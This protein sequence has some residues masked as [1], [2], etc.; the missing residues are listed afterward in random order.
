[1]TLL[2]TMFTGIIVSMVL[3]SSVSLL[4]LAIVNLGFYI[5]PML[6][7]VFVIGWIAQRLGF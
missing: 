5:I 6:I 7:L 2:E 3:V 4:I 1:M